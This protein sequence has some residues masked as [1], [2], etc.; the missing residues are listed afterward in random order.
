MNDCLVVQVF[1]HLRPGVDLS[2]GELPVHA[3]YRLAELLDPRDAEGRDWTA[4]ASSLGRKDLLPSADHDD[5]PDATPLSRVDAVLD[6]WSTET[7]AVVSDPRGQASATIR[8]LHGELV[9]LGRSDAVEALLSL[10]PL[11]KY[12]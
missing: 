4:L 3:R 9:S 11:F 8:D 6:A 1:S 5:D 10:A 7:S 12:V 2:V